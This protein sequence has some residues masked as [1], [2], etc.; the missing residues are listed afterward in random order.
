MV[1]DPFDPFVAEKLGFPTNSELAS[2]T[3]TELTAIVT[4]LC[5]SAPSDAVSNSQSN[6]LFTYTPFSERS[7]VSGRLFVG[8][9][10]A[11]FLCS[12]KKGCKH[13]SS[14]ESLSDVTSDVNVL[15]RVNDSMVS[16]KCPQIEIESERVKRR[17]FI[18]LYNICE[19]ISSTTVEDQLRHPEIEDELDQICIKNFIN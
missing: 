2:Q 17:P 19:S 11:D 8:A 1:V 18:F 16:D 3:D 6:A 13:F 5:C 12:L 9:N 10:V 7:K 14:I 4:A 15:N